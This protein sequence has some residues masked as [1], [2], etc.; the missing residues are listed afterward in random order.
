M[1]LSSASRIMT[2][3][4]GPFTCWCIIS[5]GRNMNRT[6]RLHFTMPDF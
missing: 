5:L 3:E 4:V 2:L 1:H 6:R